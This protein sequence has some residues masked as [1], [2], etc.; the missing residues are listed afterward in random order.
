[1]ICN[2]GSIGYNN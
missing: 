1:M 2:F